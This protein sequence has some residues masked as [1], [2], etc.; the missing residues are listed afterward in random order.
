MSTEQNSGTQVAEQPKRTIER[1]APSDSSSP[2]QHEAVRNPL[3]NGQDAIHNFFLRNLQDERAGVYRPGESSPDPAVTEDR[4]QPVRPNREPVREIQGRD[5]QTP[6][7]DGQRQPPAEQANQPGALED[8]QQMLEQPQANDQEEYALEV[9]GERFTADTIRALRQ[10]A[11]DAVHL[12]KDYTRKTQQISRVRQEA[13]ALNL[14]LT[15]FQEALDRKQGIIQNV[16]DANIRTYEAMDIRNMTQEQHAQ[17]VQAYD[18]AQRGK[19][20]LEKVFA[21]AETA[22]AEHKDKVFNR[23]SKSTAQL[24]RFHEPRWDRELVFYGK[25][26]EFV[27]NEGLMSDE[28]FAQENDFFRVIGLISMMDRHTLP[29]TIRETRENPR[30]SERQSNLPTRDSSG[31]FQSNLQ[32]AQRDMLSSQN[33]RQDGTANSYFRQKLEDERRRGVPP[34][35]RR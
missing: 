27:V 19:E 8:S 12:E 26:R 17:Y 33:A 25:L 31:R 35:P 30:P 18:Q 1:I 5:I 32:G 21:D 15:D 28:Q 16:I 34:Q 4:G 20:Q 3:G 10:A 22:V 24:I 14:Q 9:D 2:A 23:I 6:E 7:T 11:D 29:E 13:E